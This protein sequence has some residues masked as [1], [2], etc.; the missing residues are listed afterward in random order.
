[1]EEKR[2]EAKHKIKEREK[3]K[4]KKKIKNKWENPQGV[5]DAAGFSRFLE[6][7]NY[8]VPSGMESLIP[9]NQPESSR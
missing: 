7:T 9:G 3:E 5:I 6:L 1:M 4:E 8:V 2:A